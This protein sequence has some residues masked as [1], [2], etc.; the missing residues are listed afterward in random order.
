MN[1]NTQ[2]L[3][4]R[5]LTYH[6]TPVAS[7]QWSHVG[8][9]KEYARRMAWW[10]DHIG[11]VDNW[12]TT[13][14]VYVLELDEALDIIPLQQLDAHLQTQVLYQPMPA[15]LQAALMFAMVAD[16]K[17]ITHFDLA[18]PYDVLIKLYT[19]GGYVRLNQRGFWEVSG[20][21]G[22]SSMDISTYKT[23][24]PFTTLDDEEL[25]LIDNGD[26]Q[27]NMPNML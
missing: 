6:F 26:K 13:N 17:E 22:V 11:V 15:L 3:L 21:F 2:E 18:N 24:D 20:A 19:R 5:L 23:L 1:H 4:D 14:I 12:L 27:S 16:R 10:A 7:K 25:N 9:F 8:L